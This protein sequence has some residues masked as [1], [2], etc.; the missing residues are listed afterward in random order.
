LKRIIKW[1]K[2]D[3]EIPLTTYS[4]PHNLV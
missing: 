1:Q 3:W 4:A 2:M